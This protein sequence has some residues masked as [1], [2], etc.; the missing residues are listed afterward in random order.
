MKKLYKNLIRIIDQ[1]KNKVDD[2]LQQEF[3]TKF[4]VVDSIP[5]GLPKMEDVVRDFC[6]GNNIFRFSDSFS[7]VT[8]SNEEC[9][10]YSSIKACNIYWYFLNYFSLLIFNF[11]RISI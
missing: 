5:K 10:C 3:R 9:S 7:Q 4:N 8:R 11:N 6:W 1:V 2:T